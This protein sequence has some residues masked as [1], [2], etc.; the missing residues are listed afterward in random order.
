MTGGTTGVHLHGR[1]RRALLVLAMCMA[2]LA[3]AVAPVAADTDPPHLWVFSRTDGFRHGSIEHSQQV[4][5]DLAASTGAFTVEFSEDTADLTTALLDRT[6]AILFANTTGEHPFSE[7]QKAM[8]VDWLLDGGGF[9][10]IH[11]AADTNYQWPEYQE[12]VGAAFESHPHNGNQMGGFLLD[13][14]TVQIEDTTHPITAAW[15][16]AEEFQMREEYYRWRQNPRGTQDVH[17]LL[18]LD[19]T[20]TYTGFG[21]LGAISPAYDDDQP[22]EWTKSFRGA[23]RVWYTNLGHY[24]GTYG[25]PQWQTHFV[26]AVQWVTSAE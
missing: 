13:R 19:E 20:S 22:L 8:F 16:G 2:T 23:N 26:A 5:T 14:A 9:M 1:G 21:Q 12:L 24:E 7:A 4:I 11:A 18:S 10:G 3:S 15:D 6:D 17:V 25:D